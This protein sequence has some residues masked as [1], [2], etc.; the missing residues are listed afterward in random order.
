MNSLTRKPQPFEIDGR[1][2]VFRNLGAKDITKAAQMIRETIIY[3][4]ME[5]A[6]RIPEYF[7]A[8]KILENQEDLFNL[9]LLFGVDAGLDMV[10][11][12][13]SD[14]LREVNEDGEKVKVSKEMFEDPDYM[15]L[16]GLIEVLGALISHPDV[17]MFRAAVEAKKSLPFS[18]EAIK[19][20]MAATQDLIAKNPA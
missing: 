11:D 10:Y 18:K 5:L 15:P 16:Y 2:F 20:V 7:S 8:E 9:L 3:G 19:K 4:G 12:F 17:H 1:T 14:L 6:L 13:L